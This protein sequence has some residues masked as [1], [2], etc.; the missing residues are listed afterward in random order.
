VLKGY[1][2]SSLAFI[3]DMQMACK[4]MLGMRIWSEDMDIADAYSAFL[5]A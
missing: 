2:K 1:I 5:P 4:E 3:I